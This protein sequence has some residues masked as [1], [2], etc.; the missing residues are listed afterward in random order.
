MQTND[1]INLVKNDFFINYFG[2]IFNYKDFN[3]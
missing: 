1:K 3:K 2:L